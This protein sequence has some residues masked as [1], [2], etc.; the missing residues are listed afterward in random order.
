M[1]QISQFFLNNLQ[2]SPHPYFKTR[3]FFQT[4]QTNKPQ[5]ALISQRKANTLHK[6]PKNGDFHRNNQEKPTTLSNIMK[7]FTDSASKT[8]NFRVN[9]AKFHKKSISSVINTKDNL[10]KACKIV[11]MEENFFE[12][13]PVNELKRKIPLI[14][15]E[16]PEELFVKRKEFAL[17]TSP[18]RFSLKLPKSMETN[19]KILERKAKK[20]EFYEDFAETSKKTAQNRN[21]IFENSR[22]FRCKTAPNSLASTLKDFFDRANFKIQAKD[23]KIPAKDGKN[24]TENL[25]NKIN[26]PAKV[27]FEDKFNEI[28]GLN[29]DFSSKNE[30]NF[31]CK[32]VNEAKKPSISD[33]FTENK[34]ENFQLLFNQKSFGPIASAFFN[35]DRLQRKKTQKEFLQSIIERRKSIEIDE[36]KVKSKEKP[37]EN[38]ENNT[39]SSESD[40]ENLE[41]KNKDTLNN[42]KSKQFKNLIYEEIGQKNTYKKLRK[43]L[44]EALAYFASLKIDLND[45]F[46]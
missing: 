27:Y 7:D 31:L 43:A 42:M 15:N 35:I 30:R 19:R 8:A 46:Y 29:E 37:K 21:K 24:L 11:N 38:R 28:N 32:P 36:N 18:A 20:P 39:D 22:D 40:E 14:S 44:R 9:K 26:I 13:K 23:G 5:T 3:S 12:I 4:K 17:K 1:S 33:E 6:T 25:P 34:E 2:S 16:F 45:V 41:K 10:L